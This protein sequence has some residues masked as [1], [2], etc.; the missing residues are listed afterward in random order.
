[1]LIKVDLANQ[2]VVEVLIAVPREKTDK[3]FV[4]FFNPAAAWSLRGLA[5][6]PNRWAA[7]LE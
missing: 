3:I 5:H 1:V 2:H 6:A 7:P 4:F